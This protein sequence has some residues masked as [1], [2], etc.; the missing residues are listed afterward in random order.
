MLTILTAVFSFVFYIDG[1][2]AHATTV[3]KLE[4]RVELNE[5][6][7]LYKTALDNQYFYRDQLRKYPL[8]EDLKSKLNEAETEVKDLKQ[9]ITAV[10]KWKI[11]KD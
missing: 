11:K 8:D 3:Q 1:R 10:K 7:D 2:Y 4:K 5:L 6:R 9:L